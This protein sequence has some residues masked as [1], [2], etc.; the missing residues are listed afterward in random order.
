M[1]CFESTVFVS[2]RHAGRNG[3]GVVMYV[4]HDKLATRGALEKLR[5]RR[6]GFYQTQELRHSFHSSE[7]HLVDNIVPRQVGSYMV[8]SRDA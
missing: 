3:L 2:P 4:A 5:K 8:R 1:L 6:T 7:V